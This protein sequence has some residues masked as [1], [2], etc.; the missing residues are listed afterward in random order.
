MRIGAYQ[1]AVSGNVSGNYN[2]IEK[3]I[4]AGERSNTCCYCFLLSR[5]SYRKFSIILPYVVE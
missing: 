3:A 5:T 4:T 1:F 2:E